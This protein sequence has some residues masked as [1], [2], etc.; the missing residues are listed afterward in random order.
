MTR[1]PPTLAASLAV[2]CALALS[3]IAA[4]ATPWRL[5]GERAVTDRVDHDSIPVTARRGDWTAIQIRVKGVAVQFRSVVVHF[6]NGTRH[7]VELRDVIPAGGASRVIDLPGADRAI[8]RI[9]LVYDS[10]SIRGK[11]A[12]VRVFGRR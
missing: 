8:Q 11:Q 12:L 3:S 9:E 10:Q 7:A 6:A 5:L 2:L 1:R 4:G